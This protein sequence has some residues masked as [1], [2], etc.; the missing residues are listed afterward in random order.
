MVK[1]MR[2]APPPHPRGDY[3]LEDYFFRHPQTN[4]TKNAFSPDTYTHENGGCPGL[5]WI[6][7]CCHCEGALAT[8]AISH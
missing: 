5:D 2:A 7:D 8:A 3:F 4:P 6:H 1:I